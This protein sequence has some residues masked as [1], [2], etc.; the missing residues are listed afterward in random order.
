MKKL[1]SLSLLFSLLISSNQILAADFT[2]I[3]SDYIYYNSIS[4]LTDSGCIN[5]YEDGSFQPEKKVTRA[6]AIKIV[7]SCLDLPNIYTE[8]TFT[9]PSGTKVLIG[10]NENEVDAETEVK[11][12]IPFDSENYADLSF[13]DIEVDSWYIPYMKEAVV[14]KVITGYDDNTIRPNQSVNKAELY[15]ILYRLTPNDL[16]TTANRDESLADDIASGFWYYEPLQF[17][18]ENQ[19]LTTN[20]ENL[21]AP[22]KELSRANVSHFVYQYSEWLNERIVGSDDTTEEETEVATEEASNDTNQEET[23][24]ENTTEE[25]EA[26]ESTTEEETKQDDSSSQTDTNTSDELEVGFTEAGIASYYGYSFDGRSTASGQILDVDANMAA[27]KTLPFGTI[28]RITNPET[29]K[30]VEVTI[31][32]RGPFVPGRIIDLTPSSFEAISTLSSG[33]VNVELEVISLP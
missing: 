12:K 4:E 28:V 17:A 9:V 15:T 10:N 3:D 6:E 29:Q 11:F 2:D 7:L 14:R 32:D 27:H 31:F 18:I 25:T 19:L 21:V 1:L 16:K 20:D 26:N 22:L 33:I 5:G 30:W 23:E 24:Q 13:K 8:Q